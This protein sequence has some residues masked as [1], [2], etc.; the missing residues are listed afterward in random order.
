MFYLFIELLP[1]YDLLSYL[2]AMSKCVEGVDMWGEV[3]H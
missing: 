2:R 3:I 1:I